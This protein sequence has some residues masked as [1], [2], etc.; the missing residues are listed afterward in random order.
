M[1]SVSFLDSKNFNE[2]VAVKVAEGN[3]DMDK[4]LNLHHC[5][6]LYATLDNADAL[7]FNNSVNI[8]SYFSKMYFPAMKKKLLV[9][10][11]ELQC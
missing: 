6:T 9:P 5:L 10:I 1:I 3:S 4:F 8:R 7:M 11:I 2:N